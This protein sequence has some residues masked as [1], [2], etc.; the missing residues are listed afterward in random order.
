MSFFDK[1]FFEKVFAE[2]VELKPLRRF[3]TPYRVRG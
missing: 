3:I 1:T 2:T